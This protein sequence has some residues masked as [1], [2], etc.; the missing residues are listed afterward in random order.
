[1][2]IRHWFKNLN[3]T[4]VLGISGISETLENVGIVWQP[5]NEK[6]PWKYILSTIVT[7]R[8][9]LKRYR[10]HCLLMRKSRLLGITLN[11]LHW[12]LFSTIF[13]PLFDLASLT[14]NVPH[15]I[16]ISQLICSAIN[17]IKFI[18]SALTMILITVHLFWKFVRVTFL[19]IGCYIKWD[20]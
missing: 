4:T 20:H 17:Y 7:S 13:W 12:V 3:T 18:C 15:Y 16:E 2:Y 14:F 19:I 5:L 11:S 6:M 9:D 10:E 8:Y 1:M